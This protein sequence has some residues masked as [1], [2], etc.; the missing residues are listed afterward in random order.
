M[1]N[2]T[3]AITS[4]W[5]I[6][7]LK[8]T[9]ISLW[10][11]INLDKYEKII[12]EDSKDTRIIEKIKYENQ[13]WFLKWWKIIFTWDNN[14][15]NPYESHKNALEILYSNI[16]TKYTFHCEDD[17][18][19]RKTNYDYIELSKHIL[20]NNKNIWI[21]WLRDYFK[22]NIYNFHLNENQIFSWVFENK[23]LNYFWFSFYK[24]K[25]LNK[26]VECSY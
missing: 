19:F 26:K 3:I 15:T 20:E 1:N 23:E 8:K 10:R 17:W 9:I 24:F 11:S 14:I 25:D 21:I 7:L 6:N 5:R 18:F 16:F 22:K 12:T 2:I 13:K 4:C